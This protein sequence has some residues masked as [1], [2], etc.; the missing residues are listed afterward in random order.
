MAPAPGIHRPQNPGPFRPPKPGVLHDHQLT[1]PS[2]S[3]LVTFC[4]HFNFEIVF[5]PG[6]QGGKPDA[7]TKRSGNL[8]KEWDERHLHQSQVVLKKENLDSKLSLLSDSLSNESA[9]GATPFETQWKK[10]CTTD[11]FPQEVLTMLETGTLHSPKISLA[12]CINDQGLLRFPGILYVPDYAPLRLMI[13]RLHHDLPAAGDPGRAKTFELISS[14]FY[15]PKMWQFIEQHLRNCRT[16]RQ[17]KPVRHS[18]FGSLKPLPVPQRPWHEVSMD[19]VTGCPQVKA[20]M[21][22]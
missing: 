4:S 2:P 8:A 7:L 11:K 21:P 15:W 10:G 22:F 9:Q 14:E 5:Q 6:K 3:P 16:C 12:E 1:Q 20:S 13:L 19:F 17:A 18:P